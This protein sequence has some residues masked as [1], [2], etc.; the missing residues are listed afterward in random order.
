MSFLQRLQ[1][2]TLPYNTNRKILEECEQ[3]CFW[4][5]TYQYQAFDCLPNK[6]LIVKL[7]E[8]RF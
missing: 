6:L 4:C 2:A 8:N 1:S 5:L 7:D 3:W